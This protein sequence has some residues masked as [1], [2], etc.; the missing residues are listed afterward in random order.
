MRT[1]KTLYIA[2]PMSGYPNFNYPAFHAAEN[3]LIENGYAVLSPAPEKVIPDTWDN[4][5]RAS[6]RQVL[7][8][9]G[10]ACLPGWEMSPGARLEVD[11]A[12]KLRIPVLPLTVWLSNAN[13]P[14]ATPGLPSA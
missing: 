12:H 5:L 3:M 10:V 7:D 1:V 14:S 2:G 9:S 8:A 11:I 6:I 4:Y 13:L